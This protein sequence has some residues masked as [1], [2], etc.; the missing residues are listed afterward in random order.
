M[1]VCGYVYVCAQR[2][3]A[4][5]ATVTIPV[6]YN[7][8]KFLEL[9]STGTGTQTDSQSMAPGSEQLRLTLKSVLLCPGN[10]TDNVRRSLPTCIML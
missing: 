1:D 10:W 3:P 6:E 4:Y 7:A 5:V 9:C 8:K 2:M